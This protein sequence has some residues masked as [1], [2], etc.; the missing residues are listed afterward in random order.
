MGTGSILFTLGQRLKKAKECCKKINRE[1]FGNIQQRTK[2]A[3]EDL[4]RIQAAL[5]SAPSE[6]LAVEESAARDIWSFFA[7]AQESFFKLK[8]RI[9]WLREG[10][11]NTRF[12]HRVVLA[13]QSWNAIRYLR[14]S[15]GLRIYDQQQIKG[16]TVA[17]F[18][19]LLGSECRGIVP[20]SVDRIKEI[21]PFRCSTLLASDLI[22]IP[23]DEEI[24]AAF[25]SMPKC[26]AP[27]PDGFP[28]E[29]FL[30]A[31][32]VVGEDSIQAIK[33]FFTAGRMLRKFNAT[34]VA[35]LPKITGAD[36]LSKFRPVSCCSTVY[37]V[38]ARLLKQRLQLFVSE[39]VQLNQ[40]GFIKGR[41]LCE[42]VLLASE[43][44]TGFHKRGPTT[45]GCLQIDL[46]KAYD[47]INWEFMLNVLIAFG[48]PE[49]FVN[50]IKECITTPSFS[51][52]FNAFNG[53]LLDCFP[54]KKGFEAGGSYFFTLMCHSDG[55]FLEAVG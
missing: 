18:K 49:A 16:M 11:S 25:F 32:E 50:W 46:V 35:L 39:A 24:K 30:D 4:E 12:F 14:D 10:D 5:L 41:L 23:T 19:Q 26:K 54:G 47:N 40:V 36:E 38:I 7:S 27:G 37:K 51:I 42:N 1:G 45:R 9:R 13:N 3:L 22:C 33:E 2:T 43:L 28:A 15:S 48:L 52:A 44:V 53:E 17:Y 55:Y 29:F 31:W 21:H 20:F 6:A 34:T 8:S